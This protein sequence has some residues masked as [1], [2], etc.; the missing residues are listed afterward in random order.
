MNHFKKNIDQESIDKRLVND[1]KKVVVIISVQ[2]N[3]NIVANKSDCCYVIIIICH[4]YNMITGI[5]VFNYE[6]RVDFIGRS[7]K[8]SLFKV[9]YFVVIS[10]ISFE[11]LSS[12]RSHYFIF[13]IPFFQKIEPNAKKNVSILNRISSNKS[14]CKTCNKQDK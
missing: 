14:H 7:I 11:I 6:K 5:Q 13:T 1:R 9:F 8:N 10:S 3:W 2:K 4:C 12:H